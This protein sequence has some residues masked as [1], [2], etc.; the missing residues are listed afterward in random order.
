MEQE[1]TSQQA[2]PPEE[3]AHLHSLLGMIDEELKEAQRSVEKMD[4]EY[5]EAQQYMADRRG[6]DNTR[7]MFQS[8]MLLGQIDSQG[9]SAVLYRDRLQKTKSSPYFA[10]ID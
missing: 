8:Q 4:E 9:A 10:R 1:Q 2:I 5:R 6:E 3:I 7:D